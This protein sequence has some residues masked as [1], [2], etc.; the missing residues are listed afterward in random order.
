MTL[1][2]L[3]AAIDALQTYLAANIV[4]KLDA[5]DAEYGDFTLD[6]VRAWYKGNVPQAMPQYPSVCLHG[7]AWNPE[8]QMD[9]EL[10]I[11][12]F[13]NLI[14]FVAE[15]DEAQRFKKLCRYARAM[16]ELLQE[17]ESSYGYI[18]WLEGRVEVTDALAAP[19][20]LQ[21]V[22]VPVSLYPASGETY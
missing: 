1:A 6:D 22:V 20:F 11:K 17:G 5:L 21:A 2:L 13:I 3:E 12:N 14:V 7:E 19:P 9:T 10:Y 4:A 8:E 15:D 18:H 16:I